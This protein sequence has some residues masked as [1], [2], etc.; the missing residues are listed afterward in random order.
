MNLNVINHG[1]HGEIGLS[2]NRLYSGMLTLSLY[3]RKIM[4]SP[5]PP[6]LQCTLLD[7]LSVCALNF[8][9]YWTWNHV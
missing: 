3:R 2:H 1:E 8:L 7:A 5:C 4:S 6:W 9:F